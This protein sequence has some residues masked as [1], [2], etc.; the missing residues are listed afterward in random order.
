MSKQGSTDSVAEES[1][2]TA[3]PPVSTAMTSKSNRSPN[4]RGNANNRRKRGASVPEQLAAEVPTVKLESTGEPTLVAGLTTDSAEHGVTSTHS[5]SEGESDELQKRSTEARQGDDEAERNLRGTSAHLTRR[6]KA[7]EV[8]GI[9]ALHQA[10]LCHG[11]DVAAA[12]S[13]FERPKEALGDACPHEPRCSRSRS[14]SAAPLSPAGPT[15]ASASSLPA[16]SAKQG[17]EEEAWEAAVQAAVDAQERQLL[18]TLLSIF[19]PEILRDSGSG[20]GLGGGGEAVDAESAQDAPSRH[21]GAGSTSSFPSPALSPEPL[22]QLL[23]ALCEDKAYVHGAWCRYEDDLCVRRTQSSIQ[24]K[25]QRHLFNKGGRKAVSSGQTAAARRGDGDGDDGESSAGEDE[26]VVED[27]LQPPESLWVEAPPAFTGGP[28][29]LPANATQP[30]PASPVTGGFQ[31]TPWRFYRKKRRRGS[32]R[33]AE[34]GASPSVV[35]S[36]TATGA[37]Q[38]GLSIAAPSKSATSGGGVSSLAFSDVPSLPVLPVETNVPESASA[39][40]S[41]MTPEERKGYARYVMSSGKLRHDCRDP[42]T[43]LVSRAKEM[44]IQWERQHPMD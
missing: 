35:R 44:R 24:R 21:V 14:H 1:G 16:L 12:S 26:A 3:R 13:R 15:P 20:W 18:H 4:V 9:P 11:E 27:E 31:W 29:P 42:Y 23:K 10:K 36:T 2:G 37:I 17:G 41:P 6:T 43:F 19:P 33:P 7:E 34:G 25:R 39:V 32:R 40:V 28:W 30:V 22:P 5:S 38:S 8:E